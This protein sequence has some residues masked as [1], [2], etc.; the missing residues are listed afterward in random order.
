M[1]TANEYKGN[2]F[3]REMNKFAANFCVAHN[4]PT[5]YQWPAH[6][7]SERITTEAGFRVSF[8]LSCVGYAAYAIQDHYSE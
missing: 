5:A 6:G 1:K 8:T 7:T 2:G 3:A 4:L